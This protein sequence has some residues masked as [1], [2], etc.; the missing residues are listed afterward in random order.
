MGCC[1]KSGDPLP[2]TLTC[3]IQVV[4]KGWADKNPVGDGRDAP[5]PLPEPSN[6][7]DWNT[8]FKDPCGLITAVLGPQN[9]ILCA[10]LGGCMCISAILIAIFG[11]LYLGVNTLDPII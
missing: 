9:M 8:A 6:R 2:A 3:D 11:I 1:E 10:W 4:P 7:V 5:H